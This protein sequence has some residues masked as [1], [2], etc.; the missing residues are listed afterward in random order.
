MYIEKQ[1]IYLYNLSRLGVMFYMNF[2]NF[3]F[4]DYYIKSNTQNK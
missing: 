1:L 4:D 2:I 3:E